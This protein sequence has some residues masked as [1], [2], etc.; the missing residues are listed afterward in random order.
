MKQTGPGTGVSSKGGHL[1]PTPGQNPDSG[2]LGHRLHT[3]II[4]DTNTTES[5]TD[6]EFQT[7]NV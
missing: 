5:A 2:G 3:L 1:T 7:G 6:L 4:S